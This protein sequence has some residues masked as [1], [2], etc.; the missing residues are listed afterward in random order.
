MDIVK[1]Y[2]NGLNL[3]HEQMTLVDYSSL[4][5]LQYWPHQ[6][7][8]MILYLTIALIS[9]TFNSVTI[10]VLIKSDKICSELYLYL[11]NL[12]ASDIVMS[13]L[14]IPFT[15]TSFVLNRWIFPHFLCPLVNFA[16]I[17][18]V[19]VSIWTLTVIGI[20]R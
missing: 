4:E 2:Q 17:C 3:S 19:F 18:S 12:S 20:D 13:L 15:Y 5:T 11:I 1:I 9:F 8:L 6:V 16:Q 14:C 10:A 7:I